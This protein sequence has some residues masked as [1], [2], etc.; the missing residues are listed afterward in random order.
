[1]KYCLS[2]GKITSGEPLFCNFCG[3][4]FDVKLCPRLHPNPRIATVCSKC[5]SLD[6]SSPHPRVSFW[7]HVL[8]YLLRIA[9]GALLVWLSLTLL[10]TVFQELV[11]RPAFQAGMVV[12]GILLLGLWFLWAMLPHWMQKFIRHLIARKEDKPRD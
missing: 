8:G 5:G 6:L 4:S 3:S 12:I 2:C 7:W 1:M 11:H 9:L 10:V